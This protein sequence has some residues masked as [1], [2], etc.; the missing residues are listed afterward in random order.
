[1]NGITRPHR[2]RWRAFRWGAILA[3]LLAPLAGMRFSDQVNWGPGDFVLAALLLAGGNLLYEALSRNRGR[4]RRLLVAV[5][6]CLAILILWAQGA[7][8]IL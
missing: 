2:G 7:V 6:I 1:M 3:L 8:G 4:S 5:L